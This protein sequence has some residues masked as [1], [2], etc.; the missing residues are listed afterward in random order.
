MCQLVASRYVLSLKKINVKIA[1]IQISYLDNFT[2][3]VSEFLIYYRDV[4]YIG[5]ASFEHLLF[6][7][8]A[9]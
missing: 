2:K 8:K 5:G 1:R 7:E 4:G 3:F 9:F 6:L